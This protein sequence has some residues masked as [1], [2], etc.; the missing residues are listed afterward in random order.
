MVDKKKTTVSTVTHHGWR[1]CFRQ[2]VAFSETHLTANMKNVIFEFYSQEWTTFQRRSEED[3]ENP[4][5]EAV[6][7]DQA[8][9]PKAKPAIKS[10]SQARLPSVPGDIIIWDDLCPSQ[11]LETVVQV[12]NKPKAKQK[13]KKAS[14]E[15][16]VSFFV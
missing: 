11:K 3:K 12:T 1:L 8:A 14:R 16:N 6:D 4:N 13:Q 10:N 9:E 7:V 2:F 15:R 5:R